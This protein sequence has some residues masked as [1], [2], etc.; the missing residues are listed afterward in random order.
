MKNELMDVKSVNIPELHKA[1]KEKRPLEDSDI[2]IYAEF[3]KPGYHQFVIYDPIVEKAY[4]KDFVVNLNLR[5][6][7]YPEYPVIQ[8]MNM[9]KGIKDVF[10]P[11]KEESLS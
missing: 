10:E 8:G 2:Y 4:C 9:K 5:E 1:S 6:D 11:W 7:I 3:V